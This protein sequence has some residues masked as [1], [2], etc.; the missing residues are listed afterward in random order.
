MTDEVFEQHTRALQRRHHGEAL[1]Q[2]ARRHQR[3][4][5]EAENRNIGK[6]R[7]ASSPVSSKQAMIGRI[8]ACG[9][10][11]LEL[12]Q[13]ARHRQRAVIVPLDGN[14]PHPRRGGDDFGARGRDGA[15]G[16]RRL[17]R[18]GGWCSD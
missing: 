13:Q 18:H 11:L 16:V 2:K 1:R 17:F 9:L 8:V 4:F 10:P 3:G 14:R 12:G 5:A 7:A 15:G 6:A